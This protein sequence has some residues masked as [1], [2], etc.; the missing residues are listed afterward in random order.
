MKESLLNSNLPDRSMQTIT[1]KNVREWWAEKAGT[2]GQ[3]CGS[4][5]YFALRA[6]RSHASASSR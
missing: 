4:A 1:E 2:S 6:L 5:G 3:R